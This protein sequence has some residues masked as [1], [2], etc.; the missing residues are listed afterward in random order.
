[1]PVTVM[2]IMAF[3]LVTVSKGLGRRLEQ[4]EIGERIETIQITGCFRSKK[5]LRRVQET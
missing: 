3:A 2:T 4:L 5:R 1:M